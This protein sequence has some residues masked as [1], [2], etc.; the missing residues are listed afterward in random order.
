[1]HAVTETKTSKILT[2]PPA[3]GPA[4]ADDES[5]ERENEN[6]REIYTTHTGA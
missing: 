6:E 5:L 3:I 4:E 2:G 1:L